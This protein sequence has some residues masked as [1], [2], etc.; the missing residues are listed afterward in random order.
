M[1]F[2]HIVI[3]LILTLCVPG[4]RAQA[5]YTLQQC[6][7]LAL[8]K[9]RKIANSQLK[10][11]ASQETQKESFTNFFPSVSASGMA[12]TADKALLS[13]NTP[14]MGFNLL[15]NGAFGSIT[16]S[17]PIFAGG[18]IING[19]KLSKLQV[20]VD[21]Q[22]KRLTENE[23]LL[24]T[25][26]LY[27]EIVSLHEKIHTINALEDQLNVL[28]KDAEVSQK[29]GLINMNDV[30]QIKLKIN[31]LESNRME[32]ENG[33]SLS[34]MSLCQLMGLEIDSAS[35]F[36][37]NTPD[38]SVPDLPQTY[39]VNHREALSTRAESTLLDKQVEAAKLQT[40]MKRGD[41]LPSVG[42]GVSYS[43]DN[44]MDK[45]NDNA[46]AF[47]SVSIPI[48]GWWGGS[49]AIKKQ[50]L[51]E[52]IALNSKLDGQEQ[53]LIQ[54]QHVRNQLDIAYKQILIAK[55]SIEQATENLRISNDQYKN[56]LEKM[57]NLLDAQSLL[58]QSKDKYV[59][60]FASYQ[61]KR[62][63]YLQVTGR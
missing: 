35:K 8:S 23:V 49:H 31:E 40:K 19:N 39:Y 41:Y 59:D 33:I 32:I 24:Q 54:M 10:T 50:R 43:Q 53:L 52:Q 18:K 25:E 21:Q 63:E 9:N 30:L 17:Q 62:F 51:E 26:K 28:R 61:K 7:A 15:K 22:Q 46:I 13:I 38:I 3:C 37:I 4:L 29:A 5:Q 56:G 16:L 36:E 27:W 2:K 42:V 12:F 48:S 11:N 47:V 20:E 44:L 6:K 1:K 57:S 34:K 60:A 58:Q 14:D 45:W 55:E